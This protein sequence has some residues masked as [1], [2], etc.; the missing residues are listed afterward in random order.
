MVLRTN[1]RTP[2]KRLLLGLSISDVIA[3]TAYATGPFILPVETSR[4]V[5]ASGTTATCHFG[6]FITQLAFTSL[7]YNGMLSFFYLATIR[8]GVTTTTF[9]RRFEPWIHVTCVGFNLITA[10]VG[11]VFGFYDETLLGQGCWIGYV[12]EGCEENGNCIGATLAWF[13]AGIWALVF[14]LGVIINNLIIY[15][16]VKTTTGRTKDSTMQGPTAAEARIQAVAVQGFLYVGSFLLSYFPAFA[17]R[18]M[19]SQGIQPVDEARYFV[20]YALQAIFLPLQGVCN[21]IIYSRPN[22]IRCRR[23][24]PNESILW[25]LRRAWIGSRIVPTHPRNTR[26]SEMSRY[27]GHRGMA[28]SSYHSEIHTVY[29]V[30]RPPVLSPLPEGTGLGSATMPAG[31]HAFAQPCWLEYAEKSAS[32]SESADDEFAPVAMPNIPDTQQQPEQSVGH[33]NPCTDDRQGAPAKGEKSEVSQV[34]PTT[35]PHPTDLS[36]S[37]SSVPP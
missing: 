21:L 37:L 27:G 24:Y 29:P 3:S 28:F 10:T 13:F 20:L 35:L 33:V 2:Y 7:W 31:R 30:T 8:F 14:F 18:V 26:A 17:V 5:W 23:D 22:Y 11:L 15:R 1:R 34:L 32:E 19:E 4:R 12:P 16:Y 6:G 25:A 9:A 36:S